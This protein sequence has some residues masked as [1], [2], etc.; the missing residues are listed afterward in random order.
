M[1][2]L[3][4]AIAAHL[5]A[6]RRQRAETGEREAAILGIWRD[7]S[8][9]L[10][11]KICGAAIDDDDGGLYTLADMRQMRECRDHYISF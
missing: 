2:E 3:H 11:F 5:C 6:Q 4:A 9:I 1:E 8:V 10:W 7:P